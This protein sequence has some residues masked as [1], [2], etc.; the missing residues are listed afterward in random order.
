MRRQ[1]DRKRGSVK[2][3]PFFNAFFL[4]WYE[5]TISRKRSLLL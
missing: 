4:F 5:K 1:E 3:A 2:I